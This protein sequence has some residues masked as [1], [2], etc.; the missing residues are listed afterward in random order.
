MTIRYWLRRYPLLY[1]WGPLA[2]WLGLIFFLSAQPD[3]P[4]PET[5]W[6]ESLMGI[7]AHI[8]LFGVLAVL[9]ART[10]REQR[11]AIF[12]AFLLT[13]LYAFSDEFHQAFVPGR[14]PDPLDLVY[15][16]IGAALALCAWAW[17][18]RRLASS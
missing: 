6:L 9:W 7:G 4:H 12:L 15:D 14:T 17:L 11:R 8:F 16:G 10:L 13:M 3:F 5:G 18:V 1:L 2:V